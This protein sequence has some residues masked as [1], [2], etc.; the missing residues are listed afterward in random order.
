MH[1][2]DGLKKEVHNCDMI[3]FT[4]TKHLLYK[5]KPYFTIRKI[6]VTY[7]FVKVEYERY[8]P[9]ARQMTSRLTNTLFDVCLVFAYYLSLPKINIFSTY[10]NKH[11]QCLFIMFRGVLYV[12]FNSRAS[13]V[14]YR[15]KFKN[16]S[17][18]RWSTFSKRYTLK[19]A[20]RDIKAC[21]KLKVWSWSSSGLKH[22]HRGVS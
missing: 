22:H 4:K 21:I 1:N 8:F 20:K 9:R 5:I 19:W 13:H 6:M 2:T 15:S 11:D 7:Y 10:I 3:L 17:I 12:E 16:H 14:A 18:W